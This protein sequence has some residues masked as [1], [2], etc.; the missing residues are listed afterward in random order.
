MPSAAFVRS[1]IRQMYTLIDRARDDFVLG[2]AYDVVS[3]LVYLHGSGMICRNISSTTVLLDSRVRPRV[4]CI[5]VI[6]AE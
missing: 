6:I 2:V 5:W 1:P 4:L 3:A